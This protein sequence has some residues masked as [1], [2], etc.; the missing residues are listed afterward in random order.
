MCLTIEKPLYSFADRDTE[1]WK[2][3]K[4]AEDGSYFTPIAEYRVEFDKL[5]IEDSD[6][7]T[8]AFGFR[9]YYV[10]A[11]WFHTFKR[12]E[13]AY[14]AAGEWNAKCVFKCTIPKG[15]PYHRGS[16]GF[17]E[18]YASKKLIIHST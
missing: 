11:G 15:S 13:D 3:L 14:K 1:C 5:L 12:E 10:G 7:W 6:L 17:G 8:P 4:R 16:S 18:G 9:E 2:V